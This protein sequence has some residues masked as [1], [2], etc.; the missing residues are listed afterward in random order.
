MDKSQ[1][2]LG[3][4]KTA[5]GIVSDIIKIA[6]DQP[7]VKQAGANL[8]K[9]ALTLTTTINNLMAPL[10]AFNF[11]CGKAKQYFSEE[12]AADLKEKLVNIPEEHIVEPKAYV[13]GPAMQ[14]LGFSHEEPEL[15]TMYLNLIASSMD[16]RVSGNTHPAFVEVV[17]QLTP[18]EATFLQAIL[19]TESTFSVVAFRLKSP[20]GEWLHL[21]KHLG[22]VTL[23]DGTP[24]PVPLVETMVEN[25]IRLGLVQVDYTL[26]VAGKDV[27]AWV[28]TRPELPELRA[29]YEHSGKVVT[30][31]FGVMLRTAFGYE[32]GKAVGIVTEEKI[33][34]DATPTADS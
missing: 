26:K 25:W 15:K 3:E 13:A 11:L 12:F 18:Y 5:V 4:V 10:V 19:A 2:P 9:T 7:D 22:N 29:K 33:G 24:A 21:L 34:L 6:G 8:G 1:S 30:T 17:K 28:E 23:S 32:F 27:Y 31:H 20:N 14:G 16:G